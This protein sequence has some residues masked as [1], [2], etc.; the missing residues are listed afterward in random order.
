MSD[1]PAL[2]RLED[3][4]FVAILVYPM[5]FLWKMKPPNGILGRS[6]KHGITELNVRLHRAMGRVA[7]C[8]S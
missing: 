5:I 1:I 3:Y 4:E 8:R 7:C 2:K 6:A